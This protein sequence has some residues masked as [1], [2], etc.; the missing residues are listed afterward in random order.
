M[1]QAPP[2]LKEGDKVSVVSPARWPLE[3]IVHALAATL[4]R[5]GLKPFV[6]PQA[7]MQSQTA[8]G[9]IGQ[10]AGSDD[11]RA[12]A[13]N[14]QLRDPS[15]RAIF[16]PRGGTGSYRLLEKLDFAA[17]RNDP[18]IIV[19]FSD[20]DI[21]LDA[22]H[23][24]AEVITFRGPMGVN[25]ANA[26][27]DPRTEQECFDLLFGRK[28]EWVWDNVDVITEGAAEGEIVGGNLA[29]LNANIGTPFEI[30]TEQKIFVLE[31]CDELLFRLDRF[32]YQAN[33]AK[34]FENVRAVLFGTI[35][36]MLE[37]EDHDGSGSPF[38]LSLA[39]M[40]RE[41][42]PASVPLA[43]GLPLGHGTHLSSHPIGVPVRVE[44][45]ANQVRMKLITPAV[46]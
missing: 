38:G 22:L 34:K 26:S 31:E 9:T 29:V 36:N 37:G 2:R 15:V 40:L 23:R 1:I 8:D 13:F 41:W 5:H 44:M 30:D 24:Q 25:F 4:E 19:G 18:K 42:I 39:D 27:A 35:E 11:E 32:L 17:L 28:T 14:A 46:S 20:T 21:L 12:D 3:S 45:S 33:K 10:M 6:H 16:F 43:Y 7:L